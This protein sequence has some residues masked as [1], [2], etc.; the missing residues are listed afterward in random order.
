MGQNEF[1]SPWGRFSAP[2]FKV[3]QNR[4]EFG[5]WP[6]RIRPPLSG[7]TGFEHIPTVSVLISCLNPYYPLNPV[8]PDLGIFPSFGDFQNVFG[9]FF[10]VWGLGIFCSI[11][12][13]F[14]I[15]GKVFILSLI[16]NFCQAIFLLKFQGNLKK[17]PLKFTKIY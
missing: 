4:A 6:G 8:L 3:G 10:R 2:K 15:L 13:I 11:L 17:W 5:P 12:G 16:Q 9:I 14:E 7:N 1:L